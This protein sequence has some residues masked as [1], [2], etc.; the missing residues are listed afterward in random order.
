MSSGTRP[1][2]LGFYVNR[3]QGRNAIALP[4]RRVSAVKLTRDIHIYI[5]ISKSLYTYTYRRVSLKR[6]IDD[7][8]RGY[9][10]PSLVVET[11]TRRYSGG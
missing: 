1:E 5:C 7:N 4:N 10:R 9:P 11:D 6:Y 2:D 8:S 3:G